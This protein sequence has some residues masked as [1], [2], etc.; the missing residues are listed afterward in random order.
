MLKSVMIKNMDFNINDIDKKQLR[1]Y[2]REIRSK[3]SSRKEKED[4]IWKHIFSLPQYNKCE[5]IF[6]YCSYNDEVNTI[7]YISRCI[8]EGKKIALP[9]VEGSIKNPKMN[10]Y[11][12]H[13]FDDLQQGVLGILEPKNNCLLAT[14]SSSTLML[15]PGLAFD[16]LGGRIGYGGGYYDYYLSNH[17]MGTHIGICFEEQLIKKVPT[18]D[19]DKFVNMI[20]TDKGVYYGSD[21]NGKK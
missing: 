17:T 11:Y 3:V 15:L 2:M 19:T 18:E 5:D 13:S 21:S 4:C 1:K 12:I 20:V 10:F 9:K 7:S 16:T 8:A 6:V 14:P